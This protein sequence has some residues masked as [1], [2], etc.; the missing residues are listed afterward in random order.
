MM[1]TMEKVLSVYR[2]PRDGQPLVF[3]PRAIDP[4]CRDGHLVSALGTRFAVA[5]GVPDLTWPR[6]LTDCDA[7]AAAGYETGAECYDREMAALFAAFGEDET[8][9]RNTAIDLLDLKDGS[10]VLETGAGTGRDSVLIAAR[11]GSAGL[12]CVQDL[13]H[14]LFAKALSR[15][16]DVTA[17]VAPHIGNACHLPFK[18]NVF[19]AYYHAGGIN[20]F[21]DIPRALTEAARVTR[22]GGRVVVADES[23]PPWLRETAYGSALIE[24]NP[25]FAATAPLELLPVSARDVSV[26]WTLGGVFYVIAFTVGAGA[27]QLPDANANPDQCP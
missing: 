15:L 9:C 6:P 21:S 16:A 22:P 10:R 24:Q 19:D 12:L 25:L 26:R 4:P 2:C 18:D 20:C 17:P 7:R 23:V 5:E 1:A 11:L 14:V 27:P 3:Q 8:K 13:S